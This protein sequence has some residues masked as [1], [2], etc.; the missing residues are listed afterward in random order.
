L[1]KPHAWFVSY[2]Y[3]DDT[4]PLVMVMLLEHVGKSTHATGV[5][6]KFFLDYMKWSKK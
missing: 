4:P 1:E 5:A 2:F 3:T 6:R